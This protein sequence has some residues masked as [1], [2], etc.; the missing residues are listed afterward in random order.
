MLSILDEASTGVGRTGQ[1]L[2]FENGGIV[3]DILCLSKTL[4]C[5]LPLAS[6]TTTAE[7]EQGCREA[8]FLWLTTHF[9]D[10]LTA[11]DGC[12][13]LEIVERDNVP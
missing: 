12:K 13:V 1:M 9:N 6:V 4:G 8:G 3:P 5:G 2:A 7:V 10:P 11:A